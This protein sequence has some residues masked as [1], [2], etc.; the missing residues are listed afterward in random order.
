MATDDGPGQD[1]KERSGSC[2]GGKHGECGH[3]RLSF[4][5]YLPPDRLQSTIVLC[6]CPCHAACPV[7]GWR[8]VPLTAWQELCACPGEKPQRAWKEDADNPW[9]GAREEWERQDAT[10]RD[11]KQAREQAF[12]AAREAAAGKS[13]DQVRQIYLDELRARG[14]D[15][16][17]VAL[18]EAQTDALVGRPIRALAKLWHALMN[19]DLSAEE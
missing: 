3:V 11:R 13:R 16:P 5:Q 4:R 1:P 2:A 7:T 12:E 10:Q 17:P 15:P 14:Q 19:L 6:R 9:P 18:L 8:R